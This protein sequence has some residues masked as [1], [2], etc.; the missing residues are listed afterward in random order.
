MQECR[1]GRGHAQEGT[2]QGGG[3]GTA[4]GP[5]PGLRAST[6]HTRG[7]AEPAPR[8]GTA[9]P[10]PGSCLS[11]DGSSLGDSVLRIR[12]DAGPRGVCPVGVTETPSWSS[13]AVG[14]GGAQQ[15]W[16][17]VDRAGPTKPEP[18]AR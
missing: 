6:R 8:R 16:S 14:S 2:V 9:D 17:V 13:G 12:T 15:R 18:C 7:D 1:V 4:R 3:G 10:A 11:S 5:R